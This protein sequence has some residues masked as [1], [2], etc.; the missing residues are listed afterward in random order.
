MSMTLTQHNIHSNDIDTS[1]I[2]GLNNGGKSNNR[3]IRT[4]IA[5]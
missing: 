5:I 3:A 2:L 4:A 1:N